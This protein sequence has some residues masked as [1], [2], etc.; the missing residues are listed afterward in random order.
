MIDK[1]NK[2]KKSLLIF[3]HHSSGYVSLDTEVYLK[4]LSKYFTDVIVATTYEGFLDLPYTIQSYKNEARDFG[5]YSKAILNNDITIYDRVAFVNDSNSLVGSFQEIFKWA[6]VNGLDMWGLTDSDEVHPYVPGWNRYH[7]QSHFLVFEKIA[8]SHLNTFFDD[9]EFWLPVSAHDQE[10][11]RIRVIVCYEYGL[12]NY[13]SQKGLRLGAK[14]SLKNW[15]QILKNESQ[16][17]KIRLKGRFNMHLHLWEELINDGYPLIKNKIIRGEWDAP[18][19]EQDDNTH[20]IS[21]P[22]NR[23]KYYQYGMGK[24]I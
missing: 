3:A 24:I 21:N 22:L 14:F 20:V 8:V 23:H 9:L 18:A 13:M 1:I 16:E 17:R 15:K 19:R 11:Q 2:T 6:E 5:L 4:E 10:S 12:S 7:I